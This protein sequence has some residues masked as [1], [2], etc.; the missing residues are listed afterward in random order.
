MKQTSIGIYGVAVLA[1]LLA[2][3]SLAHTYYLTGAGAEFLYNNGFPE[4]DSNG[5]TIANDQKNLVSDGAIVIAFG[6]GSYVRDFQ[7]KHFVWKLVRFLREKNLMGKNNVIA[8]VH[9]QVQTLAI[10][11]HYVCSFEGTLEER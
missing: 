6:D 11:S 5:C 8:C 3:V 2:K 1:V 7:P 9:H 4:C 10:E